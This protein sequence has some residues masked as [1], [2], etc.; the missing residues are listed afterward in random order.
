[1]ILCIVN[2]NEK[3]VLFSSEELRG[4]LKDYVQGPMDN[5]NY[6]RTENVTFRLALLFL[7]Y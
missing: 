6:F 1:M 4:F 5:D 3:V 7:V 2:K